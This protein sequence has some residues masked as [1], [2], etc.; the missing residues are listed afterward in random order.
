MCCFDIFRMSHN[1]RDLDESDIFFVLL[2]SSFLFS[3]IANVFKKACEKNVEFIFV[4]NCHKICEKI[5]PQKP[6]FSFCKWSETTGGLP[7]LTCNMHMVSS[8]AFRMA[9][10]YLDMTAAYLGQCLD[11]R[12]TWHLTDSG[13]VLQCSISKRGFGYNLVLYHSKMLKGKKCI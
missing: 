6:A 12:L 5:R 3:D 10:V 2:P 7:R 8:F 11:A 1:C 4:G 9:G 13:L